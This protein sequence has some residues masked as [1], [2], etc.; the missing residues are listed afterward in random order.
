MNVNFPASEDEISY[1]HSMSFFLR[2]LRIKRKS[3]GFV[4]KTNRVQMTTRWLIEIKI[5]SKK[6]AEE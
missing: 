3:C 4:L 2:M 5:K 6:G 1:Y